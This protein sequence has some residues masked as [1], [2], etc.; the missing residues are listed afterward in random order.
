MVPELQ[1]PVFDTYLRS[2]TKHIFLN[3]TNSAINGNGNNA[4]SLSNV[5]LMRCY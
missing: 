3:E 4:S 2:G 5:D 1:S